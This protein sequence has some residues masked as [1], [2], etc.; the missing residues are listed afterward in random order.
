MGRKSMQSERRKEIIKV[1]Y[2][3]AKKEGLEN[4]SIAKTASALN[5]NPSLILHYFSTKEELIFGLIDHI[6]D[7]YLLIYQPDL[8]PYR[9]VRE[10]LL[11]VI[12]NIF[13][14]KWNALFDDGVSYSC[15]S[16]TFRHNKIKKKYKT[17]LNALREALEALIVTGNRQGVIAVEDPAVTADL[18]FVLADGAYYY[19]SLVDN[20]REYERKLLLYKLQA[21]KLLQLKE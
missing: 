8:D 20:R 17:L 2:K 18:I 19:L 13:S 5:M 12:D 9:D 4:A 14:K 7:K 3:V 10:S 15:Y 6:L 16:L 1:F 21:F 11:K